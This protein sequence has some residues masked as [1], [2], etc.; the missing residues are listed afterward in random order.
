MA[1]SMGP[2]PTGSCGGA[3]Q[4][5]CGPPPPMTGSCGGTGQPGCGPPPPSGSCGGVGQQ[6]CGPPP[7]TGPPTQAQQI[8]MFSEGLWQQCQK[9]FTDHITKADLKA[10]IEVT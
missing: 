8:Q 4:P 1:A 2:P 5:G 3:G 7:M 6:G 9:P 10:M